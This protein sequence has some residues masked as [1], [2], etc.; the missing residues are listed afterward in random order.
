M[1]IFHEWLHPTD[2]GQLTDEALKELVRLLPLGLR[3]LFPH[4]STNATKATTPIAT[5]I[6]PSPTTALPQVLLA[7]ASAPS[8]PLIPLSSP[9]FLL[10]ALTTDAHPQPG[11]IVVHADL[12]DDVVEQVFEACDGTCGI[13]V[14]GDPNKAKSTLL[15]SAKSNGVSVGWWEDIWEA[16][17]KAKATAEQGECLVHVW[18]STSD[19]TASFS[20]V[21]SYFYSAGPNGKPVI[22][23]VTHLVRLSS[24]S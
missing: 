21:H 14:I 12:V 3:S 15:K 7:L 6:P 2:F 20:D 4:L 23:K 10:K 13:L 11:L 17:E 5:L 8:I 24:S 18:P 9:S 1:G 16:G 19:I 22:A